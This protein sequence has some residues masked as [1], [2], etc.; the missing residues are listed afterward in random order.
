MGSETCDFCTMLASRGFV[1]HT[2]ETAG[3]FDHFHS[4][5]RC[6]VVPGFPTM[7][8]YVRNGVRV[9]RGLDP[10]VEGYDPDLYYDMW[11]HSEKYAE[12]K[13]AGAL[14]Y[15]NDT[16]HKKRDRH[17]SIYFDEVRNRDR[18]IEITT[19]ARNSGLD[20]ETVEKAYDHLF[21][22]E[23]DLETG[24]HR[25]DPDYDESESWRRLREG[26]KHAET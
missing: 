15:K 7:E 10:S 22:N 5:C 3:E 23:Y 14:T 2:E 9:S 20:K 24:H 17:A 4:S 19:I 12:K 21:I 26:G 13:I 18:G 6:K 16:D 8:R 11:K 1:Y 25:F